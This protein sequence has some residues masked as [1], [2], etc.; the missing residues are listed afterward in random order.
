MRCGH[1]RSGPRVAAKRHRSQEEVELNL[2]AMLDMA[3]QL[4]AFFILTFQAG[5]LEGQINLRL[6]PPGGEPPKAP[7]PPAKTSTPRKS[8]KG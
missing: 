6:P 1:A 8:P 3:F 5:P 4:L 2:A 7:S